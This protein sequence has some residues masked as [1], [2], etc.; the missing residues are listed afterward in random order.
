MLNIKIT[1]KWETDL[2][3]CGELTLEGAKFRCFTLEPSRLDPVY[4]GHPCI[5]AGKYRVVL[6]LSQ[7]FG[8]VTPEVLDV[9]GRTA[10]RWHVGNKPED[11]KG[12]TALGNWHARNWVGGSGLTFDQLMKMLLAADGIEVE[13]LEAILERN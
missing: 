10:I 2:S 12:C 11:V 7:R 4:A 6:S 13:Y 8:I 3:V 1:R 9:P 5:P